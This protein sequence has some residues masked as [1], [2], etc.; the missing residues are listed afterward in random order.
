MD[1]AVALEGLPDWF[2]QARCLG[3]DD[4]EYFFAPRQEDQLVAKRICASCPVRAE[5]LAY[6]LANNE[7]Y[8]VWGGKDEDERRII[9]REA[10]RQAALHAATERM[11]ARG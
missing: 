3:H 8:G 4:A 6:A 2:A 7:E 9:K 5:C 1:L 10:R 11:R